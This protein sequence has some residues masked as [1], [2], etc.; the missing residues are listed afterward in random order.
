MPTEVSPPCC[1]VA[2]GEQVKLSHMKFDFFDVAAKDEP[3]AKI[4]IFCG[5]PPESKNKEHVIPQWLI[6]LTGDPKRT[7]R[8][9]YQYGN[10]FKPLDFSISSLVFPACENCNNTFSHM[11]DVAKQVM[12]KFLANKAVSELE[13][14]ALLNWFDKVR[15]GL[16]LGYFNLDDFMRV[17][18]KF[19]IAQRVAAKDR[20]LFV[21]KSD[22]RSQGLVLTGIQTP[23]FRMIPS[24]FG[25]CVNDTFFLNAS[26]DSLVSRR[27]GF[28]FI[29]D[30]HSLDGQKYEKAMY[31]TG[32]NRVV[33]P[34]LR[35]P[36]PVGA[37]GFY[38][39]I[40]RETPFTMADGH[41]SNS[42]VEENSLDLNSGLGN[43]FWS[44]ANGEARRFPMGESLAWVPKLRFDHRLMSGNHLRNVLGLQ[45]FIVDLVPRTGDLPK[46]QSEARES[47]KAIAKR[48]N[49]HAMKSSNVDQKKLVKSSTRI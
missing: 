15:I 26:F 11:E 14:N 13:V 46:N 6:E 20:V 18:P 4:C 33:S 39:P 32:R 40:F 34:V 23:V 3:M 30:W 12:L 21:Y 8:V 31:A 43:M 16:W 36:Y 48:F 7:I 5:R 2:N 44:E 38:Q 49:R 25:L 1:S 10:D 37:T 29:A 28:P 24:C 17:N 42:Y 41:W 45:N 19:H 35:S 47:F 9:G 22:I 27:L